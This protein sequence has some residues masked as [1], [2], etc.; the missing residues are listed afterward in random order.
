MEHWSHNKALKLT[1]QGGGPIGCGAPQLNAVLAGPRMALTRHGDTNRTRTASP[2][3]A[4]AV[5]AGARRRT[6][7]ASSP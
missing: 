1:A 3:H 2:P 4:L 7:Q 5:D 6:A